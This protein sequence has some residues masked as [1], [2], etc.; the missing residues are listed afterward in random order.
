MDKNILFA[1]TP[2]DLVEPNLWSPYDLDCHSLGCFTD[3]FKGQGDLSLDSIDDWVIGLSKRP[4]F[5]TQTMTSSLTAL[6]IPSDAI[7]EFLSWSPV[8]SV[9]TRSGH[10]TKLCVLIYTGARMWQPFFII[11]SSRIPITS[12]L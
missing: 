12:I 1:K 3:D 8:P 9:S 5:D 4:S 6:S 10:Y 2:S 7:D 11:F